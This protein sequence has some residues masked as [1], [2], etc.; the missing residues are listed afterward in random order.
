VR[1]QTD[2][3]R[4]LSRQQRILSAARRGDLGERRDA[5]YIRSHASKLRNSQRR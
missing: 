2:P 5:E 4:S 3:I 1:R